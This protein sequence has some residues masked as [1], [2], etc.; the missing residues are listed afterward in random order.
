[1]DRTQME[2]LELTNAEHFPHAESRKAP[3]VPYLSV[4]DLLNT[5]ITDCIKHHQKKRIPL[6]ACVHYRCLKNW[7]GVLPKVLY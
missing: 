3:D 7:K 4:R 6:K 5:S 2:R 1:M